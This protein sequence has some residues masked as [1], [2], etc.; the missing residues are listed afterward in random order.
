M[1]CCIPQHCKFIHSAQLQAWTCELTCPRTSHY[2]L[3]K[4][5]FHSEDGLF[6][7]CFVCSC[8]CVW[9]DVYVDMLIGMWHIHLCGWRAEVEF[10]SSLIDLLVYWGRVSHLTQKMPLRH[11]LSFWLVFGFYM[12]PDRHSLRNVG[13]LCSC[14]PIRL[15]LLGKSA[16][17]FTLAVWPPM[18]LVFTLF[19]ERPQCDLHHLYLRKG[20]FIMFVQ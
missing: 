16:G 9:C 13:M 2:N 15:S 18:N 8:I 7:L 11:I 6:S 14:G 19:L 1:Q 4:L 17:S 5:P 3:W 10:L 12:Q 20:H